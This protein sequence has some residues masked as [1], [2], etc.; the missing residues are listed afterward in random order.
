MVNQQADFVSKWEPLARQL[1]EA[2]S[3]PSTT[4]AGR[5]L[6]E[7]CGHRAY[8]PFDDVRWARTRSDWSDE[9][10]VGA[11]IEQ[12]LNADSDFL[13][14]TPGDDLV[15]KILA[16]SAFGG[17]VESGG[18]Q[19][20]LVAREGDVRYLLAHG[21][22]NFVT[23]IVHAHCDVSN[24]RGT[25]PVRIRGRSG[26][27]RKGDAGEISRWTEPRYCAVSSATSQAE[28][29]WLQRSDHYR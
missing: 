3:N 25:L 20:S 27:S 8:G 18:N 19:H 17:I 6:L 29:R 5:Q 21:I 14:R 22:V 26:H 2:V 24:Q 4:K 1:E 10:F 7:G 12:L 9:Y 11:D 15:D 23:D 16:P 28:C 13:R